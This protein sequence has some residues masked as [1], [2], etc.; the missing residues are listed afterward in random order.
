M[1]LSKNKFFAFSPKK[2]SGLKLWLKADA[3][4]TLDGSNVIAWADQSGNG[5]NATATDT[6]TLTTIDGKTFIDFAGGYFSGNQF[7]TYPSVTIICVANF[8]SEREVECIFQQFDA[9]VGLGDNV[10]FYRGHLGGNGVFAIYNGASFGSVAT[11]DN[12]QT[13]LFGVII[14]DTNASLYLNGVADEVG[15]SGDSI[16]AGPYYLGRWVSSEV[17]TTEMK[18]A[19]IVVY[20]RILSTQEREQV[21]FYLNQKYAIY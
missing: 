18:M 19:E 6:P 15:Y 13:Y 10:T 1:S 12:N 11:T 16:P 7:L 4:V 20:N 2:I 21:E 3:G 14:N 17:T 9:G 5:N 8:T